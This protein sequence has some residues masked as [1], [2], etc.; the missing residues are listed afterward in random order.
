MSNPDTFMPRSTF[1]NCDNHST[2]NNVHNTVN[3]HITSPERML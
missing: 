1:Y 2:Y 3:N